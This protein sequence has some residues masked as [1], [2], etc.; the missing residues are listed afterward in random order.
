MTYMNSTIS[1]EMRNPLNSISSQLQLLKSIFEDFTEIKDLIHQQ[2][3]EEDQ[4]ILDDFVKQGF[5][6]IQIC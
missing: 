5:S 6:S 2:L 4:E 3:D 1:H